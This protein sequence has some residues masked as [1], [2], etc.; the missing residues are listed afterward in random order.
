MDKLNCAS[1]IR[2]IYELTYE[3][4]YGN[5]IYDLR[6]IRANFCLKLGNKKFYQSFSFYILANMLL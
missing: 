6:I 3:S 1:N 2:I 5:K 4:G